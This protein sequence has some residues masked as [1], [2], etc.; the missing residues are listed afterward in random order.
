M[1]AKFKNGIS[2]DGGTITIP[3]TT[4]STAGIVH[5]SSTGALSTSLI[6]NT[7]VGT[8]AGI[9][10]TK[11]DLSAATTSGVTPSSTAA[12]KIVSAGTTTSGTAISSTNKVVDQTTLDTNRFNENSVVLASPIFPAH[13]T[14][15][16]PV[17]QRIYILRVVPT[18][19]MTIAY[20]AVALT[21][22]STSN[23]TI[24]MG[25]YDVNG[26]SSGVGA[27]LASTGATGSILNSGGT[28]AKAIAF[29]GS[30]TVQLTANTPYYLAF[31]VSGSTGAT[32]STISTAN[33]Q[34]WAI[35]NSA[36][37]PTSGNA[38]NGSILAMYATGSSGTL[39]ST[40]TWANCATTTQYPHFVARTAA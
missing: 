28:I 34:T 33:Y 37:I 17:S 35:L 27:K 1:S 40:L 9:V 39:P 10:D 26:S 5:A 11:L 29:S 18:K 3:L 20:M 25:I 7:D 15:T 8:G 30:S 36:T 32:F 19:T 16:T 21:A 6:T 13:T 12:N 23:D 24:D 22:G 14:V 2:V 4:A 31:V 38:G